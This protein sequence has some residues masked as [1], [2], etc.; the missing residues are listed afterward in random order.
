MRRELALWAVRKAAVDR[1]ARAS[2]AVWE[3]RTDAL[4]AWV[5][6]DSRGDLDGWRAAL[7]QLFRLALLRVPAY[8]L[9]AV[10]R[11]WP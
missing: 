10:V 9:W 7:D 5:R 4:T 1:L 8:G 11:A 3:R 2:Y 6:A